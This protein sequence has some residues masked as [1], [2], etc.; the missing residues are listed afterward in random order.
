VWSAPG[1]VHD[2][3]GDNPSEDRTALY[4]KTGRITNRF[5]QKYGAL[6][7]QGIRVIPEFLRDPEKVAQMKSAYH[8]TVCKE[9]VGNVAGW[10][11]E[12]LDAD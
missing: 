12:E 2:P 7:C 6:Y 11:L 9:L 10:L 5:R 8:E 4:E 3:G 1:V